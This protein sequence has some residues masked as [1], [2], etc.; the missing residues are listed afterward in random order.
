MGA[1]DLDAKRVSLFIQ[2]QFDAAFKSI[3]REFGKFFKIL[4]N[5]GKAELIL[6]KDNP[7]GLKSQD[8]EIRLPIFFQKMNDSIEKINVTKKVSPATTATST[9]SGSEEATS[10]HN[11]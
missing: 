5:G 3:N 4:F 11:N 8:Q 10:S 6:I 7:S 2:Q 9:D 1:Q